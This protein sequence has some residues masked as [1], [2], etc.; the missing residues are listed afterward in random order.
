MAGSSPHRKVQRLRGLIGFR[1]GYR[2]LREARREPT[3]PSLKKGPLARLR[4]LL[5][6]STITP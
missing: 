5:A 6:G 1:S 3:F 2:G 4:K